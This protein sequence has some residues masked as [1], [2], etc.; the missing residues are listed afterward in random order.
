M[1]ES[2][3]AIAL[4]M[5]GEEVPPDILEAAINQ[6]EV[7]CMGL[8]EESR[9]R[10]YVLGLLI[11]AIKEQDSEKI[12]HAVE[13]ISATDLHEPD[14]LLED[15]Q[16]RERLEPIASMID[17]VSKCVDDFLEH[18]FE[19]KD[20]PVAV[21]METLEQLNRRGLIPVKY[22]NGYLIGFN[23]DDG[24]I[25][26]FSINNEMTRKQFISHRED[27][28]HVDVLQPIIDQWGMPEDHAFDVNFVNLKWELKSKDKFL[29][30]T[31][32]AE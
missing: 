19:D 6:L 20:V 23:Q 21:G 30:Q 29:L 14:D 25:V 1:D 32:R 5:R 18:E 10:K 17:L 27:F 2:K 4:I 9:A 26:V 8:N 13:L 22:I 3:L 7:M 16:D 15:K 12:E 31:M 11:D 28:E 24:E